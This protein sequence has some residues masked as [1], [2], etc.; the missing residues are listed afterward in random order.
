MEDIIYTRMIDILI[1]SLRNFV[2]N[3]V[4]SDIRIKAQKKLNN[5]ALHQSID[6]AIANY[7]E[8]FEKMDLDN[9]FDLQGLLNYIS[10]DMMTEVDTYLY[11]TKNKQRNR[12]YTT[13]INKGIGY[14]SAKTPEAKSNVRNLL[15]ILLTIIKEFKT[16]LIDNNTSLAVNEAA[17]DIIGEINGT[18]QRLESKLDA[19]S[20]EVNLLSEKS[21]LNSLDDIKKFMQAKENDINK[22]HALFPEYGFKYAN[23]EL[24]SRPLS[25]DAEKKYP[26]HFEGTV[27]LFIGK[28]K[29]TVLDNKAIDLSYRTQV[30]IELHI[31]KITKMLGDIKDPVQIEADRLKGEILYI[32]PDPFPDAFAVSLIC[33]DD[34]IF[35]YIKIRTKEILEDGTYIVTNEE[36][37]LAKFNFMLS[38]NIKNQSVNCT[39]ASKTCETTVLLSIAKFIKCCVLHQKTIIKHLETGTKFLEGYVNVNSNEISL[40]NIDKEIDLLENLTILEN[41]YKKEIGA[42]K[43]ITERDYQ[44]ILYAS[45]LINGGEIVVHW[46][47]FI[48]PININS[49]TKEYFA[50]MKETIPQL[51]Y[52]GSVS[53]MLFGEEYK[54]PISRTIKNITVK[55][56]DKTMSKLNVMDIDD[57]TKIEFVSSND[58]SVFIDRLYSGELPNIEE[59]I[60]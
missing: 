35:D 16:K 23:G 40:D 42:N 33:E 19:L 15:I 18:E 8:R 31:N 48:I 14:S 20:K 24:Y 11:A 1:S 43:T 4:W 30:P 50:E 32:D 22:Y 13:I 7:Q 34:I 53:F 51:A 55:N 52:I 25:P 27:E 29:L 2:F 36:D 58:D 41:Y 28:T 44:L 60:S 9:E 57:S 12:A 47:E 54:L 37:K 21:K 49:T 17:D 39:I 3:I 6:N 56:Y 38:I 5:K 59:M 10:S 26:P 45:Q 46:S